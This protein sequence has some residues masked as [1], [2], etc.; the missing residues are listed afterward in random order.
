MFLEYAAR[1]GRA[2]SRT[3]AVESLEPR[4]LLSTATLLRDINPAGDAEASAAPLVVGGTAY[5]A[6]NDGVHG[7]ELWKTDGTE[8]GTV[9]VKDVQP[10]PESS[11]VYTIV[12]AGGIVYFIADD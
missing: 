12:A 10:G 8:A 3:A 4:R 6:A 11:N 5:L 9:L 1:V 2:L 7:R